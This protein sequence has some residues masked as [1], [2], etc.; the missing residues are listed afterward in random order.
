MTARSLEQLLFDQETEE[1]IRSALDALNELKPPSAK[2]AE[3][4]TRMRADLLL[5]LDLVSGR[6]NIRT[7]MSLF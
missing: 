7:Q 6:G 5:E 4:I 2:H 1:T 3:D